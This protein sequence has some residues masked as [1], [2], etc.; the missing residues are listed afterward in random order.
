MVKALTG[1]KST[2]NTNIFLRIPWTCPKK[3]LIFNPFQTWHFFNYIIKVGNE[4]VIINPLT[5][6][7]LIVVI[8]RKL[9]NEIE[10]YFNYEFCPY[11]MLVVKDD[12]ARSAKK[13][14]LKNFLQNGVT[15]TQEIEPTQIADGGGLLWSCDWKEEKLF[16]EIC[17][18]YVNLI[19][20]LKINVIMF[21]EYSLS[22]KD[23]TRK[24][25]S[26]GVSNT[27]DIKDINPFPVERN[28][29]L[30][31]YANKET[32]V[33]FLGTKVELLGFDI[34]QCQSDAD[35]TIVKVALNSDDDKPVTIYLDDTDILCLLIHHSVS[36]MGNW[37]SR[38][39][40]KTRKTRN[41]II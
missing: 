11:P 18:N 31:N 13:S 35:T 16:L 41:F 38:A 20:K 4:N 29:F 19:H 40:T 34:I 7:R 21:D 2:N 12:V 32:F 17:Q 30:S 28:T 27:V 6:L 37:G 39:K 9:E 33:R 10:K 25:R 1:S 8:E 5:L 22:T 15:K 26:G 24:K 14:A 23:T 36:S 3:I